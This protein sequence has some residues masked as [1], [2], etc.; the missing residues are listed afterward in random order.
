MDQGWPVVGMPELLNK[1]V[2]TMLHQTVDLTVLKEVVKMTKKEEIDAFSSKIIHSQMKTMLLGNNMH[3]MTQSLKGG[4]RPHLPYSLS[5]VNTYTEVISRSKQVVV[6]MKNWVGVLMT[7]AKGLKAI[8]VVAMNVVPLVELALGTL[9]ELDE[10]QGI[11]GTKVSVERRKEVLL[12]QVDLSGLD[13]WSEANQVVTHTLLAGYH[14]I[15]LLE[16]GE[17]HC[18]DLAK[19]EI[20]VYD[21]KPFKSSFKGSIHPWWMTSEHMWKRCWKWV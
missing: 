15:Y 17:L 6:I 19:H 10:V 1:G 7:I 16:P 13:G 20:R 11:Q 14:D 21:D 5:V 12:Q 2:A 3:V 9:E 18:T 4:D 8:Q